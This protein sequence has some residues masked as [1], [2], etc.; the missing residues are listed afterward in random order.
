MTTQTTA[1][2][3]SDVLAA[4]KALME[5]AAAAGISMGTIVDVARDE[6][7]AAKDAADLAQMNAHIS[8]ITATPVKIGN[9]NVP[10][11]DIIAQINARLQVVAKVIGDY[12]DE[13]L[14]GDR[15]AHI[16]VSYDGIDES[17]NRVQLIAPMISVDRIVRDKPARS[18]A[19]RTASTPA[20]DGSAPTAAQRDTLNR[21]WSALYAA[22][23]C[24]SQV[25]VSKDKTSLDAK[26]GDDGSSVLIRVGTAWYA[27]SKAMQVYFG[28]ARNAW[29]T[30][31]FSD[32]GK[33]VKASDL[34]ATLGVNES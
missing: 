18:T 14:G 30:I 15:V 34:Y 9:K 32:K 11:A 7:K 27:P 8:A 12:Q 1:M 19:N 6:A 17:G 25:F 10:L 24:P 31:F 13:N 4:M 20:A 3:Q 28:G 2:S 21:S 16:R 22:A 29:E 23:G 33:F 5:Q 26:L